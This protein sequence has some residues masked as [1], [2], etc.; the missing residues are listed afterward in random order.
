M[1]IFKKMHPWE[2]VENGS[3]IR[4]TLYLVL[5]LKAL[6][7]TPC[8]NQ[9]NPK[10]TFV[11]LDH[12]FLGHL[13]DESNIIWKYL[14]T[15]LFWIVTVT[16][17]RNICCFNPSLTKGKNKNYTWSVQLLRNRSTNTTKG[18]GGGI[19]WNLS[20]YLRSL[21]TNFHENIMS[22]MM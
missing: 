15:G 2:L 11:F 1:S 21:P 12:S 20:F 3:L 19:L 14:T 4:D 6:F 22:C 16:S 13:H 18:E 7:L 10:L 8:L 17:G 5:L 9:L